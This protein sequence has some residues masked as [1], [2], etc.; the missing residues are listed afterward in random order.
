[1]SIRTAF[2]AAV[3]AFCAELP[4]NQRAWTYHIR[5]VDRSL[6][7]SR[8]IGPRLF[9][10]RPLLHRIWREDRDDV[11]HSHPW[12][13][14][15]FLI[16]SG[17]YVEER[18]LAT[19]HTKITT[20]APGDVNHIN[21]STVHRVRTVWPNTWTVGIVGPRVRD[22]GFLVDGAIVPHKDYFAQLGHEQLSEVS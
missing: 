15:R 3:S 10:C 16:L 1:M 14:A 12:A 13:W 18:L 8:T 7:L 21:A 22:W 2:L 4:E 6:Y 17:G 20:F 11:M 19:G 5:G 9:G